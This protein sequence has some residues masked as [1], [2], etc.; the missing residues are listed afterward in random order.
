MLFLNVEQAS[1]AREACCLFLKISRSQRITLSITRM[2]P[3]KQGNA[4]LIFTKELQ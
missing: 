3:V 2:E 4:I 1:P